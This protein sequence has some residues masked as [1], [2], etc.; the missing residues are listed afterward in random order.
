MKND[1]IRLRHILDAITA[2]EG[3]TFNMTANDFARDDKTQKA[4]TCELAIIGEAMS[5]V[6]TAFKDANRRI[7]FAQIIGMR[8]ILIHEY[9]GVKAERLWETVRDDLPALKEQILKI[10]EHSA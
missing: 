7:P 8:N 10:L 4:V 5:H 6:T 2:I 3:F 1:A 9:F